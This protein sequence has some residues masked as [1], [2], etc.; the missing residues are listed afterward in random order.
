MGVDCGSGCRHSSVDG[1]LL[2]TVIVGYD[3]AFRSVLRAQLAV[4]KACR[5]ASH[6]G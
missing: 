3:I 6:A 4:V 2:S 5:A 1:G